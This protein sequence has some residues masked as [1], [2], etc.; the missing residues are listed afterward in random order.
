MSES[1]AAGWAAILAAWIAPMRPAPNWQ[2]LI[3][4][5]VLS[6]RRTLTPCRGGRQDDRDPPDDGPGA[7]A[8][9][10][11]AEQRDRRPGSPS[12]RRRFRDLR[13]WQR[14]RV[15]RGAVRGARPPADAAS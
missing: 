9:S 14:R 4:R 13:P 15:G 10:D 3:I 6:S 8:L 2:K 1:R 12:V 5:D 7:G 11:C